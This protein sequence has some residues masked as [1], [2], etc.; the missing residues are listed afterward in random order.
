MGG[1][2]AGC[3]VAD[4]YQTALGDPNEALFKAALDYRETGM[5][6]TPNAKSIEQKSDKSNRGLEVRD[7]RA[8]RG[9]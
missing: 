7:T 4:D 5:C 6:P 2:L 9:I 1:V 3:F 8:S